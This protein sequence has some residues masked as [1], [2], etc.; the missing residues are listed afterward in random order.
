MK[1]LMK[2][3]FTSK[4]S[5]FISENKLRLSLLMDRLDESH[6]KSVKKGSSRESSSFK[7]AASPSRG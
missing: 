4:E 6:F 3:F 2:G 7:K 1:K 5:P